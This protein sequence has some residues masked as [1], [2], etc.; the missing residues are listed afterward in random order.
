MCLHFNSHRHLLRLFISFQVRQTICSQILSLKGQFCQPDID[1]N[2]TCTHVVCEKPSR[3]QRIYSAIAAGKW[4]LSMKYISDSMEAGYFLNEEPYE[5]GNPK[6]EID[7]KADISF[8]GIIHA[9]FKWRHHISP[10]IDANRPPT[11]G[12][13]AGFRV[14]LHCT[15]PDRFKA[16][17]EAGGGTVLDV[18]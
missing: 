10:T 4:M 7:L 5:W 1:Y 12:A 8:R 14:I 11:S 15:K 16:L 13:F 9:A 6:N 2:V 3:S 17:L 18:K